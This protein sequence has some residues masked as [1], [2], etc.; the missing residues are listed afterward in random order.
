V[1][2]AFE[3]NGVIRDNILKGTTGHIAFC[4]AFRA[5]PLGFGLEKD[6]LGNPMVGYP[7]LTIYATAS[8]VKKA[9]EVLTT[10][11]PLKGSDYW[12]NVSGLR[13]E[14]N[15]KLLP[16]FRVRRIYVGKEGHYES[17][18]LD[19]SFLNT[20]LYKIAINYYVAQFINVVGDYT[21]GILAIDPKDKNG[22]SYRNTTIH[23]DGLNEARVDRDPATSGVQEL[24]EW[25]G[26]VRYLEIFPNRS[27]D[28]YPD[29]PALYAGPTGRIKETTCFINTASM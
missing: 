25:E 2:F 28:V 3:S 18:P 1:D 5:L 8:E 15:P 9:L 16:F 19:T 26:F 6:T 21:Y 22:I 13:V 20:K 14:Y 12:L 4:D 27:G 7:M 23:P 17:T 11:Y 10:V 24:Q 29:V